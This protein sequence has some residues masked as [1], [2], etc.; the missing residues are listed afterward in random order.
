MPLAFLVLIMIVASTRVS[1]SQDMSIDGVA[2][3]ASLFSAIADYC[4]SHVKVDPEQARKFVSAFVAVGTKVESAVAFKA[5]LEQE[6][7]RRSKEVE[8]TGPKQW[9]EKERI[10]VRSI[11]GD[12]KPVFP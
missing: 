7:R 3:S 1:S 11:G 5:R 8:I 12:D 2:R 10:V 4:P 9:C 6:T